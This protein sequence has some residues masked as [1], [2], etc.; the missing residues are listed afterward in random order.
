MAQRTFPLS[1]RP[2]Q[3]YTRKPAGERLREDELQ[4]IREMVE[5]LSR[6]MDTA[7]EVPLVGWRFG[8]DSLIGLVPG[9]GDAAT[10]LVSLYILTLAGRAGMSRA[11]LARMGLNVGI[12]FVLGSLPIVGDLFDVWWKSN[13]M[14]A[15]L[16]AERLA[17]TEAQQRRSRRGDLLF[18][19]AM[20]VGLVALLAATATLTVLAVGALWNAA[21]GLV[22]SGR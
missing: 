17:A 14:N 21:G 16:L 18:V 3:S 10:S 5:W 4:R 22:H 11:T 12:D 9:V 15:A 1:I 13:Q 19:G 8:L 20:V 7:F 2:L 6:W